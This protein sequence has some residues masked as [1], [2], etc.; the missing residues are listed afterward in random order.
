MITRTRA[1]HYD[2]PPT[3]HHPRIHP[4]W[5]PPTGAA[6]PD[7]AYD[8]PPDPVPFVAPTT[9]RALEDYP[10]NSIAG[11]SPT[12][13]PALGN[14]PGQAIAALPPIPPRPPRPPLEP[15]PLPPDQTAEDEDL[16]L[17]T[18][19]PS[20]A[21]GRDDQLAHTTLPLRH[22]IYALYCEGR[23]ISAI[24]RTL[25]LDRGTVARHLR[26]IQTTLLAEHQTDDL[27]ALRLRAVEAQHAILAAAWDAL[28]H[29]E[30]LAADH[31]PAAPPAQR[32][33]R[34]QLL[35]TAHRA[36]RTAAQLQGLFTPAA[37]AAALQAAGQPTAPVTA[38]FQP[39][40]AAE[41][42]QGDFVAKGPPGAN[43]FASPLHPADRCPT[44]PLV[45]AATA[46]ASPSPAHGGGGQGEGAIPPAASCCMPA[47]SPLPGI[48]ASR[49]FPGHS[50][51]HFGIP[52]VLRPFMAGIAGR[53][54]QGEGSDPAQR[55]H[56][57]RQQ[58]LQRGG[59]IVAQPGVRWRDLNHRAAWGDEPVKALLLRQPTDGTSLRAALGDAWD[60]VQRRGDQRVVGLAQ[61][62]SQRRQPRRV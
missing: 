4:D 51:P 33:R 61:M 10:G 12:T 48:H 15:L 42:P 27:A 53:A 37:L 2:R 25:H 36:A 43:S 50:W 46:S 22:R 32:P 56:H 29:E 28:A 1:R 20:Y 13:P 9:P 18:P 47:F 59:G 17:R 49:P 58:M 44:A 6:L 11:R 5:L 24:A 38:A 57:R 7:L 55:A 41:S 31:D 23:T 26:A 45:L 8:A 30:A 21:S 14:E 39:H 62:G 60:V 40:P 19:Q 52:H 16:A 54:G 34:A 3:T 35:A